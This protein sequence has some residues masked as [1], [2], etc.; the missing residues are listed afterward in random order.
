L[1][2]LRLH[3]GTDLGRLSTLFPVD[4]AEWSRGDCKAERHRKN[5][6]HLHIFRFALGEDDGFMWALKEAQIS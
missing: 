3:K 6:A 4:L 5:M 2:W 1:W